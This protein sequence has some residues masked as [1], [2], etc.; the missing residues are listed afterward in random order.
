MITY[1]EPNE[2]EGANMARLTRVQQQAR[3]RA[4]V[5][6][7]ARAEFIEHGYAAAKVDRIA[8]R[9]ELTRGAVYSNFPGKRALYLAVLVATVE[10]GTVGH[11]PA[12]EAAAPATAEDALARFA[13][14]WL[15]RLPLAGDTASGGR[16]Q[17]RSLVG[18]IDD[19]RGRAAL[20][21]LARLEALLLAVGLESC[22]PGRRVR[23]AELALTLLSGSGVLAELAPGF[24]D[25]FDRARACGHL[26]TLDL[27]DA[28][29]PPHLP[30]VAPAQLVREPLEPV[31]GLTDLVSGGPVDPAADGL[32]TVLGIGRLAAA[33]DAVR[34]AARGERVTVVIA[35]PDPAETG[36]L[37]R[38]KVSDLTSCLRAVFPPDTWARL[39]IVV[40]DQGLATALGVADPADDT[41]AALRV[42][43]GT[44]T[45]RGRGLGAA[46]AVAR[47]GRKAAA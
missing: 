38:L 33:E 41:E 31:D 25:P 47:S 29:E 23:T 12:V 19:D 30:F 26:A 8:E 32:V 37:V 10:S 21:Q 18:V 35:V 7:A 46:Y 9:A 1:P 3:T 28:W 20:A 22:G 45:A 43:S 36:N 6:A 40:G 11:A 14:A 13:R 44:V 5:L 39:K 16:L 15:E 24:G 27:D 2:I 17:L 42:R 34:S 4:A